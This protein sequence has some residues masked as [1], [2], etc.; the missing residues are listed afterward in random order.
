MFSQPVVFRRS[1]PS[2]EQISQY[3][4]ARSE[5]PE[6]AYGDAWEVIMEMA[7]RAACRGCSVPTEGEVFVSEEMNG[8]IQLFIFC[9]SRVLSVSEH[10]T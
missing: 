3:I 2:P 1:L 6:E 4:V 7:D 5:T 9:V 10:G 8:A